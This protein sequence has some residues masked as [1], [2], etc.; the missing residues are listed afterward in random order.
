M[1]CPEVK[2]EAELLA[3]EERNNKSNI[4]VRA[5]SEVWLFAIRIIKNA[6][7]S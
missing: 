2:L 1:K 3:S 4:A 7:E 6:I 5:L